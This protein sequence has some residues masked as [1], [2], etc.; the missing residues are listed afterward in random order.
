MSCPSSPCQN[1]P[2]RLHPLADIFPDS[3]P[4]TPPTY[5]LTTLATSGSA[6]SFA[7]DNNEDDVIKVASD[8]PRLR[9]THST[10]GYRN[11]IS[12]AK[13][14]WLQ[15]GFDE[16]YSL[17]AVLGLRAGY[18]LG[19]LEGLCAAFGSG[20]KG[21]KD[22]GEGKDEAMREDEGK[23]EAKRLTKL[24]AEAKT[25]LALEKVFGKEWWGEDGMWKFAVE[26]GGGAG[27]GEKGNLPDGN[28]DDD[29]GEEVTFVEVA[30]QHP[31]L[32]RWF[33]TVKAEMQR[34]G[35]CEKRFEGEEWESGRISTND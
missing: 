34:M 15:P 1:S 32:E 19:V 12:T 14:Q 8:M 20:E 3:P 28:H 33:D 25:E 13:T 35:V 4:S 18:I 22:E 26:P 17:G 24:L 7:E 29:D 6:S 21:R 31:L 11:G 27:G 23:E 9:A 5:P 2:P 10:A 30:D 16:G